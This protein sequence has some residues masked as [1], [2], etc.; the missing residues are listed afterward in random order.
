MLNRKLINKLKVRAKPKSQGKKSPTTHSREP[1]CTIMRNLIFIIIILNYTS[2]FS[3]LK[4]DTSEIKSIRY[5]WRIKSKKKDSILTEILIEYNSGIYLEEYPSINNDSK[6]GYYYIFNSKNLNQN[7]MPSFEFH[8]MAVG[9][10]YWR[11]YFDEFG[12]IDSINQKLQMEDTLKVR[13]YKIKKIFKNKKKGKLDFLIN[14]KGDKNVYEYNFF[15]NLKSINHYKDTVL[16]KISHFKND[17]LVS[18][19]FPT[20]KKNRKKFTYEYDD[21]GRLIT[22]DDHDYYF[23]NYFYNDY[24]LIREEKIYKKR[25]LIIEY[26]IYKYDINGKLR[27]KKEFTR[28]DILRSKYIYR[29]K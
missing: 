17:L 27:S 20:R 23:W 4:I 6:F 13:N 26:S 1:L 28:N 7:L 9:S 8:V 18:E 10:V 19:T 22:R 12:I 25:N 24:G 29:Y 5:E 21:T 14:E 2:I 16:Y 3:Q 15:G 11:N